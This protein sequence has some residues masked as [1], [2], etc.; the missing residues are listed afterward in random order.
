[1][2]IYECLH[3]RMHVYLCVCVWMNACMHVWRY[4]CMCVWLCM[5][6]CVFNVC[7]GMY[8]CMHACVYVL[9]YYACMYMLIY[10][11]TRIHT[12]IYIFCTGCVV[13][14]CLFV[15]QRVS[16]S[17]PLCKRWTGGKLVNTRYIYTNVRTYVHTYVIAHVCLCSHTHTPHHTEQTNVHI[18]TRRTQWTYTHAM[19][20]VSFL[21]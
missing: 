2:Y 10:I 7:F 3:V 13:C 4:V 12:Y 1:M 21:N 8:V 20:E 5:C 14:L 15:P 11:R 19:F 18:Y 6:L 9:M 17:F 16:A